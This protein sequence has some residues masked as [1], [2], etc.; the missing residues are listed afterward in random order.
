[1]FMACTGL[2]EL[3]VVWDNFGSFLILDQFLQSVFVKLEHKASITV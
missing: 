3:V 2:L 1:M